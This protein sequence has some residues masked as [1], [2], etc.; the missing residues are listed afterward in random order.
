MIQEQVLMIAN[1]PDPSVN[2]SYQMWVFL[3]VPCQPHENTPRELP[4]ALGG[5]CYIQLDT[6]SVVV[7]AVSTVTMT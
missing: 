7:S 4:K 5:K 2:A 1:A 3:D 6:P